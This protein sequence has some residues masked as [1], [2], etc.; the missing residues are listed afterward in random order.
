MECV[1]CFD[2]APSRAYNCAVCNAVLC[3]NCMERQLRGM[4]ERRF[5]CGVCRQTF[6]PASYAGDVCANSLLVLDMEKFPFAGITLSNASE[7]VKVSKLDERDAAFAAGM[8]KGG[9]IFRINGV[10]VSLHSHAIGLIEVATRMR[11]P[12]S[13]EYTHRPLRR[14]FHWSGSLI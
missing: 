11:L 3:H 8:A 10:P 14:L 5:D 1:V 9:R 13:C 2:D 7:C 4:L 6:L 12:I